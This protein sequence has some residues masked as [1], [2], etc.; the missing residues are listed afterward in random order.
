MFMFQKD[1]ELVFTPLGVLRA[2]PNS[3]F[4]SVYGQELIDELRDKYRFLREVFRTLTPLTDL[5]MVEPLLAYP[6][7]GFSLGEYRR[8]LLAMTPAR[9]I[10]LFFDLTD[11]PVARIAEAVADDG[12]LERLYAANSQ[13]CS[14]LLGFQ[15]LLRQSRRCI[16][17]YF[18]LAQ[19]LDTD[20]FRQVLKDA[21]P[22]AAA[23]LARV[24]D[25]LARLDPLAFSQELMGKTFHNRGPYQK[26]YFAPSLFSPAKA[27]RLFARDQLLFVSLRPKSG[28]DE[29]M[30]QQLKA[31]AD[32]TRL[33]IITLLRKQGP[34]RGLDIAQALALAPSTVSHHMEQLKQGGLLA[35]E[36]VKTAK[37]Y[38]LIAPNIQALLDRLKEILTK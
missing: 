17:D 38:S 2:T 23:L 36:Q 9:F 24:Q 34:L 26:F 15:S 21:Q 33:K 10:Q 25:G 28:G 29:E 31:I 7:P 3:Y 4:T 11:V 19:Q 27:L 6:L 12:A 20:C 8:A 16:E 13:L 35:E 1:I 22:G 14:S 32:S 30:L 5:G 18:S 37:Y